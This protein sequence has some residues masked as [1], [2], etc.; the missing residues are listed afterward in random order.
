MGLIAAILVISSVAAVNLCS[1]F[2]GNKIT[3][4]K[5]EKPKLTVKYIGNEG[6]LI[7]SGKRQV[8]IDGLHREYKPAYAF[9]P[10]E[11]LE[12]IENARA[13]YRDI[14][15]VL[16]SHIH[17]DHFHP[18]S[19]GLHLKNNPTAVFASSGQVIGQLSA[20]FADFYKIK[21]RVRQV[22]HQWKTSEELSKGDIRIRFLGLRHAN[23]QHRS[24][25]NFGH[26]I[27][28]GG[29]KLLHVGDADM[30]PENFAEFDIEKEDIDVA[31]IPYWY[32]ISETGR[33]LVKE[34]LNPRSIIAVHVP[35]ADSKAVTD[36]VRGYFPDATVF[37]KILEEKT[38]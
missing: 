28:I 21:S 32:L 22:D 19:V 23:P 5:P 37:T 3:D 36:E 8:L 26:I 27:S 18:E 25:Q 35:P 17:L 38:F 12:Q 2:G 15:L 1:N 30:A 29:M 34:Q 16:V 11:L 6:I 13:P 33:S 20:N 10:I 24:I 9:P 7:S 31:V 4:P 14:D